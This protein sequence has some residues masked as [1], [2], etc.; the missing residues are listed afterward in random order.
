[1]RFW[2]GVLHS[3]SGGAVTTRADRV[4][5]SVLGLLTLLAAWQLLAGHGSSVESGHAGSPG[6]AATR[7]KTADRA[8]PTNTRHDKHAPS[9]TPSQPQRLRIP[10]LD[11]DAPVLPIAA[12]GS[13]LAPP[14]DPQTVGWWS[15]GARPG[16]RRGTAI[17]TGHTVSTGGGVFDDLDQM[18]PGQRVQIRSSGQRLSLQV[19]SVTVYHKAALAEHA[20]QI[21]DQSSAGR[22]ALV[23]CEDW[24]GAEYLSNVV[25][26]ATPTG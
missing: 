26:I 25:V 2:L 21:F 17:L 19:T 4:L 20:A 10:S 16:A 23:T 11:V 22:V 9:T 8:T 13:Q 6:A 15:A 1:M 7:V 12:D 14:S 24:D 5:F 3:P 18:Q